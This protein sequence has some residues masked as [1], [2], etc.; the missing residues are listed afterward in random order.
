MAMII[1]VSNLKGG[2]GKTTVA[3]MLAAAYQRSGLRTVLIDLDPQ[4]TASTWHDVGVGQEHELPMVVQHT[5]VGQD[6][7]KSLQRCTDS[8]ATE[9]DLIVIDTAPARGEGVDDG[10]ARQV[11]AAMMVANLVL[12]PTCPSGFSL[13][14]LRKTTELF[15]ECREYAAQ[16][17]RELRGAI[18]LNECNPRHKL[19]RATIDACSDA[20]VPL[21]KTM[22]DRRQAVAE[23]ATAGQGVTQYAPRSA[24]ARELVALAEELIEILQES[25]GE[26][27]VATAV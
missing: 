5:L 27:Q 25:H 14:S 24:A 15:H 12:M 21:L 7:F 18:C 11:R 10:L 23:A 17:G 8:L 20:G 9:A 19:T 22:I 13:W 3:T 4:A 2:V 16:A 26:D 1:T 6:L